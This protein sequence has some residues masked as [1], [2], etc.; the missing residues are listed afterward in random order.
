MDKDIL[1]LG[2]TELDVAELFRETEQRLKTIKNSL[3]EEESL[4]DS[5]NQ[6]L[7]AQTKKH[8]E[9]QQQLARQIRDIKGK[10]SLIKD[11]EI[12]LTNLSSQ[13]E[14]SSALLRGIK[15]E[16]QDRHV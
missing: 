3:L 16:F 5:T 2:G 9:Q 15:S 12:K 11:R 10:N 8:Q 4:L 6:Q 13:F 1:L 7:T 14:Q